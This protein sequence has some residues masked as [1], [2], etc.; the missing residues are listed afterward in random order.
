MR[1]LVR[2]VASAF[3]PL[4]FFAFAAYSNHT[5]DAAPILLV[6]LAIVVV[7]YGF[8]E[9]RARRVRA[10]LVDAVSFEAAKTREN[11]LSFV[12]HGFAVEVTLVPSDEDDPK[13]TL[14]RVEGAAPL[15]RLRLTL[16]NAATSRDVD[17]GR[18]LDV[19]IGDS[20]LDATYA[21][22]G[23][24]ATLVAD[25]ML[26]AAVS[27]KL[28]QLRPRVEVE[29]GRVELSVD[30]WDTIRT[31]VEL[32]LAIAH[33]SRRLAA[34]LSDLPAELAEEFGR[35]RRVE[36]SGRIHGAVRALW[37]GQIILLVWTGLVTAV[38]AG[39]IDARVSF[40]GIDL[41]ARLGLPPMFTVEVLF[42]G[43]LV[44]YFLVPI[45][46]SYAKAVAHAPDLARPRAV[47][48]TIVLDVVAIA[49]MLVTYRAGR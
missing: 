24:P 13:Q 32:G 2:R 38:A 19:Q 8:D 43:L 12:A 11:G 40:P 17:A 37:G 1:L 16:E 6:A 41:V 4:A 35:L 25:T 7:P 30:G 21:I 33:A 29:E 45:T 23:A 15:L 49:L 14:V 28:R 44:A 18:A 10:A 46:T 48:S 3:L 34:N 27:P 36:A 26:D 31:L 5:R 22:E 42:A 47:W 39:W 9:V 20:E